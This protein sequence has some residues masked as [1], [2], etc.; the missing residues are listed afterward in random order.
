[1]PKITRPSL[2]VPLFALALALASCGE[3][4]DNSASQDGPAAETGQ[5]Q[6]ASVGKRPV[7]IGFDGPRFDACPG[8]GRVVN[9]NPSGD[10]YLAV[11]SAPSGSAEEVDR[12]EAGR[13]V[14]MCQQVGDWIGIVYAPEAE[15]PISCG[16]GAP[17]ASV[18]RYE[19]PCNQGWVDEN[20]LK[21]VGR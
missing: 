4:I 14:S 15:D 7:E 10:T 13:G 21:L 3:R 5:E 8:F 18:G 6:S 17:V 1:M 16:T 12:L 20:Y 9:L 19:G 2:I 11:R